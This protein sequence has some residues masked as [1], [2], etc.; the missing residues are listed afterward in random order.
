MR[1]A[2]I[3]IRTCTKQ[4]INVTQKTRMGNAEK[5]TYFFS[6]ATSSEK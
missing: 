6:E 2:I 1:V 3:Q 5:T 4:R